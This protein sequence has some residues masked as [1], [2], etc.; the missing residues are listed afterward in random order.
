[1]RHRCAGAAAKAAAAVAATALRPAKPTGISTCLCSASK[2]G[3]HRASPLLSSYSSASSTLALSASPPLLLQHRCSTAAAA[4][5]CTGVQHRP[6]SSSSSSS[7]T[8]ADG[9]RPYVSGQTVQEKYPIVQLPARS[10]WCRQY[11][12]DPR[13]VQQGEYADLIAQVKAARHYYQYPSLSA[14]QS[15][16]NVQM[17]TLFDDTVFINPVNLDAEEWT[18][19]AARRGVPWVEYEE[20][21]MRELRAAGMT[22]FA[23]EPCA[24]SGFMLHYIER[25]LTVRIRALDEHGKEFTVK[26]AR[27]RGRMALHEMDHLNG[28][29]FTRRVV[30]TDHVVPMEGFVT[31]SDWSD[32]YPSLEA[33]STFLYSIFTPPYHFDTEAVDDGNLLDR[34]FED[35]VYPGCEQD[36]QQRIESVAVEELQ[37]QQWR[38]EKKKQKEAKQLLS[39]TAEF[40][41]AAAAEG[42]D[43]DED[44]GS[45][46]QQ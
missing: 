10:L 22:G 7:A 27:M 12:L 4:I 14:P 42:A 31:M 17:F 33:R 38:S 46:K 36:R 15:G 3:R 45:A 20:E 8:F 41:A 29:L 44:A 43:G 1:M 30:D 25:P 35:G 34:K 24:S 37:R 11:P 6:C 28:V 32:D 18:A 2:C 13:R 39:S 19:D 21:K 9:S 40:A 23:W 16:W 26:L 5:A